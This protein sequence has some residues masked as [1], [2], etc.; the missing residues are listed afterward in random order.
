MV[1]LGV[2][3][4]KHLSQTI[5]PDPERNIP[6][7]PPKMQI[8]KDVLRKQ[9]VEGLGYVSRG[10]WEFSLERGK[11][12]V[13]GMRD[14]SEFDMVE[15]DGFSHGI[16]QWKPWNIESHKRCVTI[17]SS[18][19]TSRF[20]PLPQQIRCSQ[21]S[22]DTYT[23][24]H[25]LYLV[26]QGI[27]YSMIQGNFWWA[28]N[29]LHRVV[30]AMNEASAISPCSTCI[31]GI[32]KDYELMSCIFVHKLTYQLRILQSWL[33]L[34][35]RIANLAVCCLL[36]QGFPKPSCFFWEHLI[37][38]GKNMRIVLQI[39][40]YKKHLPWRFLR[41]HQ[42]TWKELFKG[43]ILWKENRQH[44]CHPDDVNQVW[45]RGNP[46]NPYGDD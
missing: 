45:P 15:E 38:G 36:L 23:H 10:L 29:E 30:G 13:Q 17:N 8:W 44:K 39:I 25:D 32:G 4:F 5:P 28:S 6:Q 35:V 42:S 20:R 11:S 18:D 7:V 43:W 2:S 27:D 21:I 9:V 37:L 41:A 3:A 33:L 24:V 31:N 46:T 1:H 12:K 26:F 34:V 22:L 19:F 14:S 40:K 16:S